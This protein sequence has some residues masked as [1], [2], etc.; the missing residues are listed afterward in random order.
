MRH[1][2]VYPP[3]ITVTCEFISRLEIF[4]CNAKI[5]FPIVEL[6]KI[7]LAYLRR[8]SRNFG[9]G[10]SKILGVNS[11]R[12]EIRKGVPINNKIREVGMNV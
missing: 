11:T 2:S 4:M 6:K 5:S 7:A 3:T 12:M 10:E 9:N 8:V 1:Y